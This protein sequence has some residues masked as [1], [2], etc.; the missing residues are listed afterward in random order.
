MRMRILFFLIVAFLCNI[1]SR[2]QIPFNRVIGKKANYSLDVPG[3]YFSK[4]AIG[5]NVD[6]KY[7]NSEGASII[8]VVKSLPSDVRESDIKH[9]N[10]PSE[11][12]FVEEMESM[13]LQNI[14]LI[15]RGFLVVNGVKS[16]F[17]YYRDNDLYY[18]S[19]TQFKNRKILNLTYTCEY[20][21]RDLYMP[22]IFRV[23][24]SLRWK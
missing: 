13:G 22:Y 21:S 5:A 12:E 16:H 17:A 6:I 4:S 2:A 8:T 10:D 11:Y 20:R 24:N 23:V 14:S 18:H 3:N 1:G 19:I 7:I 15:K 9:M